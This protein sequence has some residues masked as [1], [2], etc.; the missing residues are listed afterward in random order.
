MD[1]YRHHL[2]AV[3]VLYLLRLLLTLT[4]VVVSISILCLNAGLW[5]CLPKRSEL[6]GSFRLKYFSSDLS[7]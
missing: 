3:L 7:H 6:S 2:N 4:Q 5:S 1:D